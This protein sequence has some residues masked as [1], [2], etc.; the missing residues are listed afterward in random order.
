[1]KNASVSDVEGIEAM[2]KRGNHKS[3]MKKLH[4]EFI[5]KNCIK[6]VEAR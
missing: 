5:A 1:M 3:A 2:I 6:E 4:S